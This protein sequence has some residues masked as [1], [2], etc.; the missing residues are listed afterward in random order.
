MDQMQNRFSLTFSLALLI[1]LQ[2]LWSLGTGLAIAEERKYGTIMAV[3]KVAPVNS[4]E[5]LDSTVIKYDRES[6]GFPGNGILSVKLDTVVL[7]AGLRHKLIDSLAFGYSLQAT[8]IIE[9]YGE[10]LFLNGRRL[11]SE[12]FTGDSYAARLG[13]TLF[14]EGAIR[15]AGQWEQRQGKFHAIDDTLEGY[16]LPGDLKQQEA[17]ATMTAD[18][19][20][21][22]G[23]VKVVALSGSRKDWQAWELDPSPEEHDSFT[24]YE[25]RWKQPMKWSGKHISELILS[26]AQGQN[27]DLFS[28]VRVGGMASDFGVLGYF[29]N[30]Y[31]S[32]RVSLVNFEHQL[33]FAEDR[34]L[35][36]LADWGT[37]TRLD[38]PYLADTPE[39]GTLAGVGIGYF[40]GIR[41]LGGLPVIVRYG[42]GL[43]VPENSHESKRREVL[44]VLAAAF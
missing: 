30:E 41:S 15:L 2:V 35:Y 25:M 36:L 9:G 14:P 44:F 29:R 1:C 24:R 7:T 43:R 5:G 10:D 4:N 40:Y 39:Q 33:Q 22:E 31:R 32:R 18:V 6:K 21:T 37:F 38:L 11:R 16:Q 20:D 3:G 12:S 13:F 34:R 26:H 28:D 8:G 27:L 19:G 17:R 23:E 42:E